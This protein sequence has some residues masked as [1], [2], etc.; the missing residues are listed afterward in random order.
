M[1]SLIPNVSSAIVCVALFSLPAVGSAQDEKGGTG[2]DQGGV[3]GGSG[4]VKSTRVIYE[5]RRE[6]TAEITHHANGTVSERILD[7]D[8]VKLLRKEKKIGNIRGDHLFT[9]LPSTRPRRLAPGESGTLFLTVTLA[10]VAVALPGPHIKLKLESA[11]TP[12]R[13]GTP[14]LEPA[15]FGNQ[16]GKYQGKLVYDD[17]MVFRV[18][19]TV[20]AVA[21]SPQHVNLSGTLEMQL[22]DGSDGSA[23]GIFYT[24]IAGRVQ[25]GKPMPKNNVSGG[26]R[27]TVGNRGAGRTTPETASNT[28]DGPEGTAPGTKTG[29]TGAKAANGAEGRIRPADGAAGANTG[30]SAANGGD[31]LEPQEGSNLMVWGFGGII[32][33]LLVLIL[34]ARRK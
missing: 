7:P 5:Q 9:A 4:V 24:E 2:G 30:E 12:F 17:N 19:I 23:M 33:V 18:P 29:A 20:A 1:K 11:N 10:G 28:G 31:L 21:K 13:F 14:Q 3:E 16:K 15:T 6:G 32:V 34:V 27:D 22:N 25:V 26:P 8:E